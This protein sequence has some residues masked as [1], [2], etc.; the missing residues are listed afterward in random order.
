MNVIFLLVQE[1]RLSLFILELEWDQTDNEQVPT[2][3]A[4]IVLSEDSLDSIHARSCGYP[5]KDEREPYS[6]PN[7]LIS[8]I[9]EICFSAA[10]YSCRTSPDG[11]H[12]LI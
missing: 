2:E 6:L 11:M 8:V 4:L 9:S 5:V 3:Y 1:I 7:L 10:D 12:V